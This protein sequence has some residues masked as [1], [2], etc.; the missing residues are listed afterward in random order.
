M[1]QNFVQG[2]LSLAAVV[3]LIFAVAAH[4]EENAG[5][6]SEPA[7]DI[8]AN[9]TISEE[10]DR[11]RRA[12]EEKS[13]ALV[14]VNRQIA[15]TQKNLV[16]ASETSKSL[17][18][19]LKKI[20]YTVSQV[21]LGIRA[22]QISIEKLGL[23][24]ESLEGAIQEKERAAAAKKEVVSG[25]LRRLQEKDDTGFLL[26]VLVNRSLADSFRES[27]SIASLNERLLLEVQNLRELR[28]SLAADLLETNVKK[29]DTE[30]ER[31]NLEYRKG[32]LDD[33]KTSR[34]TLL[35]QTKN[36][37]K[38]YQQLLSELEKKQDE[39]GAEIDKI[40][41][42]LRAKFDPNLLPSRH[43]MFDYPVSGTLTVSQPYGA[44]AFAQRAYRS[45]FH[46]GI[47]FAVPIG[48]PILAALEGKVIAV[49]NNGRYQY[50][51]YVVIEHENGFTTL[52]AHLSR[53]TVQVGAAVLKGDVI[54]Y[55]GNTGYTFG[56]HLHFTVY[57]GKSF[58]LK[59]L[60]SCRCGEIPF[61]VTVNPQDYL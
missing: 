13:K 4:A 15:E 29:A 36:Q 41:E 46:N 14:E 9:A 45:K 37:E 51:K 28:E 19:E 40:E 61:G 33:Q 16:E 22:S 50:G 21:G 31:R 10:E 56:P 59:T 58:F 25:F 55:S 20:D 49:G 5:A 11:L 60:P 53:P 24:I 17:S 43:K 2:M 52:Y 57:Y 26:T 34:R 39:I 47:D 44:T 8:S 3:I 27:Q 54:G 32:I 30:R 6:V 23:E 12:I 1:T 35:T 42:E 38:T 48:T 18:K 7:S